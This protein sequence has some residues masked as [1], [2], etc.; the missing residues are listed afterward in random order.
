MEKKLRVLTFVCGNEMGEGA[1]ERERERENLADGFFNCF[2]A[3]YVNP[4][5]WKLISGPEGLVSQ[6]LLTQLM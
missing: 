3:N 4:V 5:K 2:K 6:S 1:G